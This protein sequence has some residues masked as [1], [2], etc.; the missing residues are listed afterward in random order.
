MSAARVPFG[1]EKPRRGSVLVPSLAA[2]VVALVSLTLLSV[3]ARSPYT[4]ANLLP[5]Y[6]AAYS[7]T[8]QI[9]VGPGQPYP[10]A[11]VAASEAASDPIARGGRLYVTKGCAA[12]H[13]IDARGGPVGPAI[14]G[15]D[16][17]ALRE[18]AREGPGGMPGYSPAALTGEEVAAITAYLGSLASQPT[19]SPGK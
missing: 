10:E 7:R 19:P 5:G 17:E 12:C 8:A 6:D 1:R 2:A 15:T 9:L 18:K 3:G 14:V 13:R 11:G 4:H 16:A